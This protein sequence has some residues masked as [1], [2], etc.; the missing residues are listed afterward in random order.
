MAKTDPN[1]GRRPARKGGERDRQS[2]RADRPAESLR[3]SQVRLAGILDIADDAIISVDAQQHITL[4]N[5]GAEK[6]FGYSAQ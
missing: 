2:D 6:I 3:A 1:R 4:F 5:Q